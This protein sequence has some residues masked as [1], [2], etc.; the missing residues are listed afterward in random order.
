M[1]T[2]EIQCNW[3]R[4]PERQWDNKIRWRSR[5]FSYCSAR[6]FAAA[7]YHAHI[8][9]VICSI[10][11]LGL[12]AASFVMLL[13]SEPS[14]FHLMVSL[15]IIGIVFAFIGTCT[16]MVSIGKSERRQ[17]ERDSVFYQDY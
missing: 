10:P 13:I 16:Y 8:A 14:A 11:I 4:K 12:P 15:W 9:I 17:K 2:K 7:E 5:G 1:E 6:C 3:C